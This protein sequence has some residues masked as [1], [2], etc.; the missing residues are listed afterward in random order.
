MDAFLVELNASFYCYGCASWI[1]YFNEPF[2]PVPLSYNSILIVAVL[3]NK[4]ITTHC[5]IWNI[6]TNHKYNIKF[7]ESETA[8]QTDILDPQFF[9]VD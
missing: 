5:G 7:S 9:S 8:S 2:C 3:M 4:L 6:S 1:E